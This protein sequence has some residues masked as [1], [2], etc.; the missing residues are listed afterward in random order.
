MCGPPPNLTENEWKSMGYTLIECYRSN[1]KTTI[2]IQFC[3]VYNGYGF[4]TEWGDTGEYYFNYKSRCI[5]NDKYWDDRVQ[6]G[7]NAVWGTNSAFSKRQRQSPYLPKPSVPPLIDNKIWFVENSLECA[8]H[9]LWHCAAQMILMNGVQ[10]YFNDNDTDKSEFKYVMNHG[11]SAFDKEEAVYPYIATLFDSYLTQPIPP[12]QMVHYPEP[13][14]YFRIKEIRYHPNPRNTLLWL[15]DQ[16]KKCDGDNTQRSPLLFE[17]RDKYLRYIEQRN[18]IIYDQW[19][20]DIAVSLGNMFRIAIN[21]KIV[22]D[23]RLS[24]IYENSRDVFAREKSEDIIT[25]NIMM[26]MEQ[27]LSLQ[28][29]TSNDSHNIKIMLVATRW[30]YDDTKNAMHCKHRCLTNIEE[31]W[32]EIVAKYNK[33]WIILFGN[34]AHLTFKTQYNLM[35]NVD[36]MIGQHG[37]VFAWSLIFNTH[38]QNQKLFEISI[39]NAP[40]HSEHWAKML[41]IKGYHEHICKDCCRFRMQDWKDCIKSRVDVTLCLNE[42]DQLL[43]D[44]NG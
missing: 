17:Y 42:I 36:I 22:K 28:E 27:I 18:D 3:R 4:L 12:N 39:P 14:R 16:W 8:I 44:N 2:K 9:N 26:D 29:L 25:E 31:F 35:R 30:Y 43:D 23:L 5:P 41:N 32:Q 6:L 10:T 40:L 33:N 24:H 38:K 37:A 11:S 13:G 19:F 7:R 20:V 34:L 15:Q 21:G 1:N